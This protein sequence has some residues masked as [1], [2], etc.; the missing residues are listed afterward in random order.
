[1]LVRR[2]PPV[3]HGVGRQQTFGHVLKIARPR[4][5]VTQTRPFDTATAAGSGGTACGSD[6]A[7]GGG[8]DVG[9]AVGTDVGAAGGTTVAIASGT[10]VLAAGGGGTDITA[11]GGIDVHAAGDIDVHAA[12]VSTDRLQ[13]AIGTDGSW[14]GVWRLWRTVLTGPLVLR[15]ELCHF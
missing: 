13:N 12:D 2:E 7:V 3:H 11:A 8:T 1:M 4:T 6:V 10:V 15:F 5:T 14:A 9:A